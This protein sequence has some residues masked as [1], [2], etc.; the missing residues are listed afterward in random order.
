MISEID[1]FSKDFVRM[2]ILDVVLSGKADMNME[3]NNDGSKSYATD[4]HNERSRVQVFGRF[5]LSEDSNNNI[6]AIRPVVVEA[7]LKI[8]FSIK[9][10]VADRTI[11]IIRS[12]MKVQEQAFPVNKS[13]TSISFIPVRKQKYTLQ[14]EYDDSVVV[15][16]TPAIVQPRK[17]QHRNTSR[18]PRV[19]PKEQKPAAP[20]H[21]ETIDTFAPASGSGSFEFE[22][23]D[24]DSRF[25]PGQNNQVNDTRFSSGSMDFGFDNASVHETDVSQGYPQTS[26]VPLTPR[27]ESTPSYSAPVN[28][29]SAPAESDARVEQEIQT[30]EY[31]RAELNT[32]RQSAINHLEKIEAEYRKDYDALSVE[33]E[34]IKGRMEADSGIIE[35]Y[36]DRDIIPVETLLQEARLKLEEAETQIGMF[37]RAKQ[38]KTMEIESEVKANKK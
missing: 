13:L 38:Q 11:A 16:E 10:N 19:E 34:E 21:S 37:I 12:G 22:T 30:V 24:F 9:E 25:D 36:K 26:T 4:I 7:S 8:R 2:N 23:F 15:T 6:I 18:I 35:Y 27:Y 32:R 31:K 3:L 33:L 1:V 28:V 14:V 29:A 20:V 17:E 5:N